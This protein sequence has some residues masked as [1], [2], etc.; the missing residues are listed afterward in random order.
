MLIPEIIQKKRDG[1]AL[2][3]R[4]IRQFIQGVTSHEVTDAQ[5]AAFSMA[6]FFPRF[7]HPGTHK[8]DTV[9]AGFR[10]SAGL[11]QGGR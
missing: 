5:I 2:S 3:A 7:Q 8:F 1:H 10:S 4:D 9:H 11:E 6:A